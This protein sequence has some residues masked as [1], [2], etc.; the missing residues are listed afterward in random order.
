LDQC[1]A[2][3]NLLTEIY[4]VVP[5]SYSKTGTQ[6]PINIRR[7]ISLNWKILNYYDYSTDYHTRNFILELTVTQRPG[8][9]SAG[10]PIGREF[11][12]FVFISQISP[13]ELGSR[14][15]FSRKSWP[16][17]KKDPYGQ[18]FINVFRKDSSRH[19]HVLCANF[20][21]FGRPEVGEIARCLPDKKN[22]ARFLALASARIAPK[23]CQG[24]LQTIFSECP[25]FHPNPFTSSGV[26]VGCVNIV[27]TR[28]K[29]FPILGEASTPS[30]EPSC[31]Y[32][33]AAQRHRITILSPVSTSWYIR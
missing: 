24:Q 2:V 28:H 17:G 25:K 6:G 13:P 30:N 4:N 27:E 7:N 16:F 33:P 3:G 9:R 32:S 21:K 8:Q 5:V 26:M 23:I 1:I 15:R 11:P 19:I 22:S 20:V 31:L 18:I 29:V 12:R 10:A 14:W